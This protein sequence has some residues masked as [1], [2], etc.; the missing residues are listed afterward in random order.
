MQ[1]EDADRFAAIARLV[2]GITGETVTRMTSPGGRDREI[3][4]AYLPTRSVIV[5]KRSYQTGRARE[6]DILRVL[7]PKTHRFAQFVGEADGYLV[8]SDM[9]VRRLGA[10]LIRQSVEDRIATFEAALAS[11]LDYQSAIGPVPE[12]LGLRVYFEEPDDRRYFAQGP[13]RTAA[14]FGVPIPGFDEAAIYDWLEPSREA[15]I[16]WDCRAANASVDADGTIGWFDFEDSGQGH[17][18]IDL[19][20]LACDEYLPLSF[21]QAYPVAKRLILAHYGARGAEV[22][23]RFHIMATMVAALRARKIGRHVTK[24]GKWFTLKEIDRSDRVGAHPELLRGLLERGARFA[25]LEADTQPLA[26]MFET[27]QAKVEKVIDAEA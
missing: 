6:K 12:D 3:Y 18:C 8:Q 25:A 23:Q 2:E 13:M 21:D 10:V 20:W 24:H 17:G 27:I 1:K 15:F 9:G 16:K 4:R 14:H 5:S 19:A 22:L 7:S 26:P 11:I